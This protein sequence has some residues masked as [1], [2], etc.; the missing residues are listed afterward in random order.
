MD[1]SKDEADLNELSSDERNG[2]FNDDD[3]EDD[4][5]VNND[6]LNADKEEDEF[7]DNLEFEDGAV[8]EQEEVGQFWCCCS[9]ISPFFMLA[10]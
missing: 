2:E 10:F 7:P 1:Q 6:K 5:S 9:F 3:N 4:E 8:D